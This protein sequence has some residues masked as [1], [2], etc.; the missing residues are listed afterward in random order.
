MEDTQLTLETTQN[1]EGQAILPESQ[2][3]KWRGYLQSFQDEFKLQAASEEKEFLEIGERLRDFRSRSI[4][5]ADTASSV[6]N[7]VSGEDFLKGIERLNDIQEHINGYLGHTK[8]EL[9]T[10]GESLKD[11]LNIHS[12]VYIPIENFIKIVKGLRMLGIHIK[13]LSAELPH[14]SGDFKALAA[15]IASLASVIEKKTTYILNQ[16]KASGLLVRETITK[17][18]NLIAGLDNLTSKIIDSTRSSIS[19]LS[20]RHGISSTTAEHIA[21]RSRQ[22]SQRIEKVLEHMQIHDIARQQT[23]AVKMELERV[24]EKLNNSMLIDMAIVTEMNKSCA[25][26]STQLSYVRNE[27]SQAVKG[28]SDNLQEISKGISLILEDT[29]NLAGAANSN[30]S[31]FFSEMESGIITVLSSISESFF[32][33]A[34]T[35]HDLSKAVETVVGM[36]GNISEFIKGIE[37]IG[38]EMELLSF[39]TRI[40]A[41]HTGDLGAG[42]TVLAQAVQELSSDVCEKTIDLSK[43]FKDV[44]NAA[45]GLNGGIDLKKDE[46]DSEVDAIMIE[47]EGLLGNMRGNNSEILSSLSDI[48]EEC[49]RL[50]LHIEETVSGIR[51]EQIIYSIEKVISGLND[52]LRQT[53]YLTPSET[54]TPFIP[55]LFEF[56][57]PANVELF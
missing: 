48:G 43:I 29:K 53:S 18:S 32:Q 55:S 47:V 24:G 13:I 21:L 39:N 54:E 3:L 26:Q 36:I 2:Y 4:E 12:K 33:C 20:D 1:T 50:R 52:I 6:V 15:D 40:T 8:T 38:M 22:M 9:Q 27:L 35:R 7:I 44:T 46:R 49:L 28:I 25:I 17:I 34:K 42:L 56:R 23:E 10:V 45:D 41:A 31:S 57:R 11:I 37:Q 19:S 51:I 16:T 30:S 5:I 14:E